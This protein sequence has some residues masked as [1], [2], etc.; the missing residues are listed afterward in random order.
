[1]S[2]VY[3]SLSL[4]TCIKL[5]Q[6]FFQCECLYNYFQLRVLNGQG[7]RYVESGPM[8]R[9]SY[10]AGEFYIKSMIES[11]RAASPQLPVS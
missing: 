2:F 5:T 10:K 7:F 4:S 3:Q 6:Y 9:S 1:M 8:V 11:D